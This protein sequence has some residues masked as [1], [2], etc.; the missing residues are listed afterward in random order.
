MHDSEALRGYALVALAALMWGLIGPVAKVAL[1]EGMP[2]LEVAFWRTTLAWGLFAVHAAWRGK[3]RVH[4]RDLPAMAAFGVLGIFGLF[5]FYILAVEH[6]GAALAAVL[7]YTAPAWVAV[8]AKAFLDETFG[9]AK[10]TA[11]ALTIAGVA[12]ISLGGGH[13]SL[14]VSTAAV[15][16]GLLSGFSYATYYIFG[17]RYLA[18]YETPTLFLYTLPVGA[19]IMAFNFD[20]APHPTR[21]WLAVGGMALVSTYLAYLCYYNGL[22]RLEATRASVVATLEPVAAAILAFMWWDERFSALGY[23]GAGL[24]LLAVLVAVLGGRDTAPARTSSAPTLLDEDE[25]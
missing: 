1:A 4:A 6:G 23:L 20:F 8:M 16:F 25:S 2:P 24:I 11:V 10:L 5:G 15:T 21:A 22:R 9:P 12:G 3:L 17:K 14:H 13:D 18:E 7:L 19:T